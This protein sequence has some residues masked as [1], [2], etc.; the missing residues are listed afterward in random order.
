MEQKDKITVSRLFSSEKLWREL[1]L[2]GI[3]FAILILQGWS[4]LYIPLF[5]IL[6]FLLAIFIRVLQ[7]GV[8]INYAG[9]IKPLASI[10]I[11]DNLADRLEFTGLL[12][13]LTVVIQGYESLSHPQM[14]AI[15]AP[16]FLEILLVTYLTGH[17]V[18]CV[19]LQPAPERVHLIESPNTD[20]TLHILR[21]KISSYSTI[22]IGAFFGLGTIFNILTAFQLTPS[23]LINVPGSILP[24]GTQICFNGVFFVI[25]FGAFFMAIINLRYL[26]K[27]VR[28]TAPRIPLETLSKEY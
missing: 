19:G 27:N 21:L 20:D 1:I 3:L 10:G 11:R 14:A 17:Y 25:L 2:F 18:L 24:H 23:L 13:L 15:M 26:L 7:V 22:L 4:H 16:F 12:L 8:D 6:F 28:I 5:P 9:I